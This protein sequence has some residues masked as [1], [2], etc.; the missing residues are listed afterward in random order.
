[1]DDGLLT[2]D[3]PLSGDGSGAQMAFFAVV[4]AAFLFVRKFVGMIKEILLAHYFG[5][6]ATTDVFKQV[7]GGIIT[8]LWTDAEQLLR[9]TYLPEFIKQREE[10]EGQAWRLTGTVST[11]AFVFLTVVAVGLM[12]F[13]RT[14]LRVLWPELVADPQIMALG[15]L[16]LWVM[17]PALVLYSLSLVPELT[18]HAY[19]RFTL[20]AFAEA[21]YNVLVTAVLFVGVEFLWHPDN[22]HAILAAG[23]GVLTGATARLLIMLPGLWSKLR[24]LKLSLNVRGTAGVTTMLALMPPIVMG[25]LISMARPIVDGRVCNSLG[26]GMYTALDYGR[27]LSDAG[28]MILPL[29]VSLVVFPYVS[30]WAV[31]G[32]RRRL[33]ESLLGM[34]RALAFL[35]VPVSVGLILLA[36]PLCD[37]IYNSGKF[38]TATLPQVA[39]AL[40]CYASGLFFYSV[41]GSINKWYF[42]MK[43]TWTPNWVGA[44]WALGHLTMSIVG[45]LYTPLGLAAVALA[46]PMSKTGKVI[47]LYLK[48]RPRLERVPARE[49]WPFIGKLLLSSAVMGGVVWWVAG[50]MAAALEA[51]M[52]GKLSLVVL[53]LV[54][55]AAGVLVYLTMAA[56]LRIEE[57]GKVWEW[58]RHKVKR[59]RRG[60]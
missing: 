10:G 13:A 9:P 18:L 53:L 22:P 58:A 60:K 37:L 23:A 29:A 2:E 44:L 27:R 46:Y 17:A 45:G 38:E 49:V 26:E 4:V 40:M 8:N 7:H 24:M 6:T 47:T 1:M 48:L 12:V 32:N 25:L 30:E 56:L 36:Y 15:V 42:A 59:L 43:D 35:F 5:A 16:L 55:S 57:V 41:E 52:P 19:K 20:P 39:L 33:S 21:S 14:I 11:M 28:I 51:Q 31:A 54:A 34:T 3:S 50:Q